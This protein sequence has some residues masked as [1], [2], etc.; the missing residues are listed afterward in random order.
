MDAGCRD[1]Q[2]WDTGAL[3]NVSLQPSLAANP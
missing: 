3:N 2:I 1:L